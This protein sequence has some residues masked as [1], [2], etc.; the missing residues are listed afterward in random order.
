MIRS[1]IYVSFFLVLVSC[2][3]TVQPK[4]KPAVLTDSLCFTKEYFL[5][6]Q[7]FIRETGEKSTVNISSMISD[8]M[9][10]DYYTIYEDT[11]SITVDF[12][13]RIYMNGQRGHQAVGNI[14]LENGQP[15]VE[16]RDP[17]QEALVGHTYLKAVR[18]MR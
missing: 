10:V 2:N 7:Q 12:S 3:E 1:F 17:E 15:R 6:M 9:L 18:K 8:T 4:S 14:L 16:C 11:I 5:K 13:A